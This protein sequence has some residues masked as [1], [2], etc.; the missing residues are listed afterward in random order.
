MVIAEHAISSDQWVQT[1]PFIE[2][3]VLSP[4]KKADILARMSTYYASMYA[5]LRSELSTTRPTV[6]KNSGR[7]AEEECDLLFPVWLTQPFES[8]VESA[9]EKFPET[10]AV[11][12]DQIIGLGNYIAKGWQNRKTMMM[13]G[14][15]PFNEVYGLYL[16]WY[17]EMKFPPIEDGNSRQALF[18]T[19]IGS[20][21]QLH[22]DFFEPVVDY[23]ITRFADREHILAREAW[24]KL[25][26]MTEEYE[27]F[28][29]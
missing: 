20:N 28:R 15:S 18:I 17:N 29:V 6:R 13:E 3:Q 23:Y 22:N 16:L 7:V 11:N 2:E 12:C 25:R 8:I 26:E 9:H 21:E 5:F 27:Q 14:D 24:Q 19:V 4:M 10:N 1:P